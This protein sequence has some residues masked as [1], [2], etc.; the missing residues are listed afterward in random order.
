MD[1]HEDYGHDI[2]K[3]NTLDLTIASLGSTII[4]DTT[5]PNFLQY[6]IYPIIKG[7][8]LRNYAICFDNFSLHDPQNI[9]RTTYV[10]VLIHWYSVVQ[11][12]KHDDL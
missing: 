2:Q 9:L 4:H 10:Q 7:S 11:L 8:F 1:Y 5:F 3:P 6:S 12:P